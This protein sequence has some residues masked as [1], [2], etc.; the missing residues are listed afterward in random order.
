[1]IDTTPVKTYFLELQ[2]QICQMLLHEEATAHTFQQDVWQRV[3]GG[4]GITRVLENGQILEKAGVNFSEIMGQTLPESATLRKPELAG[5]QFQA[6]GVSA[7]IHPRNPYAPTTHMNVRLF[8]ATT[9]SGKSVW[10]FGGGFD[11]TPYYGFMEDC[12]HF[13]TQAQQACEPFGKEVYPCY[14]KWADDYFYLKHRQEARGIGGIFF[15]D[16]NAWDF[17]TCFAFIKN[18]GQHFILAYQPILQRRKTIAY[19]Q[20]AKDFQLYRRGRY[21]EFNLIYDRGTLFGLQSGGRTESILMSL[22]PEVIWRYHWSPQLDTV[23]SRLLQDFLTPRD[24]L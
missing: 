15:D 18:V 14:K 3:E 23:E 2:D 1:M 20:Q 11:L 19:D 9:S 22:P 17:A 5:Q 7:V 10:W 4:G 6:L 21:V 24:W 8:C 13:H 12:K 16:L